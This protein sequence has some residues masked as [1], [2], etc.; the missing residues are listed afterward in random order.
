MKAPTIIGG[1]APRQYTAVRLYVDEIKPYR[2][3]LNER[4]MYIGLLAIPD[5]DFDQMQSW[6]RQDRNAA[7]YF[8][9]V[10]FTKLRNA[11]DAGAYNE[12]TVLA[13]YWTERVLWDHQKTFH[14]YLLGL[15]LD[16][17]QP[18]AFG[19]GREQKR[20]IY[21]RFFRA[22][23]AYVLK[24]FF[25]HGAIRVTHVF[26]DVS[27]LEHD[28]L[29]NWHAIWR[30]DRAEPDITFVPHCIQFIDSNHHDEPNFPEDSHLVQLCDVLLGALTQCLDARNQKDGCCEIARI[31]LLLVKRLVDP[32]RVRNPNSQYRYV[33]RISMSF[34][35]SQ[36]LKLRELEDDWRRAQSGF[37]I[38]R[39]LL[40][41]DQISGQ[42]PLFEDALA[43]D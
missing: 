34:F 23:V 32:A 4:W 15:N 17:L 19:T 26:H 3:A 6:L 42:L 12:K 40:L 29:F 13:K 43:L 1:R 2:N 16:N 36:R 25:G 20:N 30:L 33:R 39:R 38:R 27:E 9:E 22:S 8:G 35:P 11:S 24:Y 31:L 28:D 10:H 18:F 5:A 7:N 14:F 37:Y 21:N 41:E